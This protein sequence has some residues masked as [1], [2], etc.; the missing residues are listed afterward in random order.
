MMMLN[1]QYHPVDVLVHEFCKVFGKYGTPGCGVLG[2]PDFLAV[3]SADASLSEES[4]VYYSSCSSV[5]L[6]RQIGSRYFVS[7]ANA[8]KIIF[9]K[10]AALH[11]LKYMGKDTGNKLE[12]D[13]Y[14]KLLDSTEITQ[15]IADGLMFYHVYADL[16]MLSKSSDLRK[17]ALDMNH[18]YLELKTYLQEVERYPKVV[19][20]KNHKVFRSEGKLY[21]DNKNT[22][23]RQ[24]PKS[25]VVYEELFEQ[26]QCNSATL[27][28]L[29]VAGVMKMREKLCMYAQNQ[30]PGGKYWDP[31]EP[32][33]K[34][35]LAELKPS[36]DL[37][38]S[39]L[40][41]NDYLTTAIPNLHQMAR[42]NLV[43]VKK[44]KT[45]QWLGSLT[46]DQQC[47]VIDLAVKKR[48]SVQREYKS[49][50][51]QRIKQRRQNM[52]QANVRREAM[53]RKEKLERDELSQQHLI[54]TPD[55]LCQALLD[56]ESLPLTA[57]KMKAQ[58]LSLI[59]TQF[60]IR[61]K[62]L[63]Q[64]IHITFSRS[65]KHRP[66]DDIISELSE[67]IQNST[68]ESSHLIQNPDFFIGKHISHK[69]E[70]GTSEFRWY[71]GTILSYDT[72]TK[73][74][75]IIYE[76]EDEH[77]YFDLSVDLFNGDLKII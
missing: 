31:P 34:R 50:E 9:L 65:G 46:N 70:V 63:H 2:F 19:L 49:E 43:E 10:N 58:K 69:F 30:L 23:H 44:N 73:T 77:C 53:K 16:V 76:G 66:I 15:L 37:C 40:G 71:H 54:T 42:S 20:D 61:K 27:Y 72:A 56:I 36:N 47:E 17:S 29:L 45:L 6:A 74:H 67:Y 33:V 4:R 35:A 11:F 59:K 3:M 57:A 41:L 22:N 26:G 60:K 68:S 64:N 55:E 28:P 21:G 38:E 8:A 62:I 52:V 51:E 12:R 32:D 14:M 13:I 39:I 1:P 5:T 25:K 48:L 7:A 75:E 24:H 18:H